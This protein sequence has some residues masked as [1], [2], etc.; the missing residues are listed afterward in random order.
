[1]SFRYL[2]AG[3]HG[4]VQPILLDG[5]LRAMTVYQK[6]RV[7]FMVTELL[8]TVKHMEGSLHE[9]GLAAD[10]RTR[11]II[12]EMVPSLVANLRRELGPEWDV[13]LEKTHIHIEY[14]PRTATS[15]G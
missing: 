6:Y 9:S 12:P 8:P 1:M 2:K 13:V 11:D 14:D 3:V 5:L 10:L 15:V 7:P 4:A